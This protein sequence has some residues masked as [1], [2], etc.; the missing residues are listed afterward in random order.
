MGTALTPEGDVAWKLVRNSSL[1][2]EFLAEREEVLRH[3]WLES[4]KA[5]HDIGFE[6]ALIEWIIKH[7]AGWRLHRGL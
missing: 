3:K 5:G 4:E 6:R 1:Y 2:L 7:R